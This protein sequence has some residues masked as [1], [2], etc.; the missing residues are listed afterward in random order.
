MCSA[1][2]EFWFSAEGFASG[3]ASSPSDAPV[4]TYQALVYSLTTVFD[5]TFQTDQGWTV[6]NVS[7]STGAWQRA[8][9]NGGGTRGDPATA[10]GGSGQCYLTQNGAGDTDVDGGPTRLTS[11]LIDLSGASACEISYA[12]WMVSFAADRSSSSGAA[13]ARASTSTVPPRWIGSR[14]TA[15]TST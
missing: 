11:P 1:T 7:L 8:T 10:N 14:T 5:D 4:S 6:A 3:T 2:P 15:A 13:T 9:P 12:R